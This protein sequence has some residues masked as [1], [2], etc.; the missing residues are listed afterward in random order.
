MQA[1][2]LTDYRKLELVSLDQPTIG[3]N[4]VLVRVAACG[5]C[6]SDI[7]GYDGT[8]GRR[9]PPIVMGHEAAGIVAEIGDDVNRAK[10]GDRV[11][12]DS[13]IYC[14]Q[15]DECRRGQ[16][17]LCPSRRVLGVSCTEYR[18]HGAFAE[19]VAVPQHILYPLPPTLPFENAAL[20]EPVSIALHAVARLK[21]AK[22]ER[23]VVVGSGMIGLLVIQALRIVGCDEVIAID[24]DES[25]LE[26]AA[27]LGASI[28]INASGGWGR[29]EGE[30]PDA[31]RAGGST[32]PRPQP[33]IDFDL[34][35]EAV[36]NGPALAT[37][38][39]SVRRG[40]RVGL[41]GNLAREVPLPLQSVVTRELTLVAS[42]ASAGEYPRA[43]ELLASGAIDVAPLISAVAPLAE[44]PRW[45][46][47]L[48][49]AEPGLMK[50]ILQPTSQE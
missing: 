13:T 19:F 28:T 10:V 41:V 38:I 2:L 23:A 44:G 48:H 12:F 34:A 4:D 47:R 37:A 9:V 32:K 8:S 26:L 6:G 42:C 5:I 7:H 20:I 50:V 16:V 29:A 45:F 21:A 49:A 11:T 31:P 40:G 30:P 15:C 24:L 27:K 3:P 46:D 33:P 43:I 39:N 22:G 18:Q 14:G 35:V 25:R 1:L 17:N 36:G